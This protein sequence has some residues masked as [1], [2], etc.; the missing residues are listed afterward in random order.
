MKPDELMWNIFCGT[1]RIGDYLFYSELAKD[2]TK[3]YENVSDKNK[4]A[5]S[6]KQRIR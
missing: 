4:G 1:G 6:S 5:G 3:R 2:N